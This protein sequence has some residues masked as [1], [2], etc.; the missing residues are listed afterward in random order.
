MNMMVQKKFALLRFIIAVK[1]Y[2]A[3]NVAI[4]HLKNNIENIIEKQLRK[5]CKKNLFKKRCCARARCVC[6][7]V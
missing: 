2:D 4:N 6:V 5:N 7:C 1:D 3:S